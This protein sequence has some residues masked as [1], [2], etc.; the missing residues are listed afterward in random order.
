MSQIQKLGKPRY[1]ICHIQRWLSSQP[2]IM[3]QIEIVKML[4]NEWR[5]VRF[6][7]GSDTLLNTLLSGG[8][9]GKS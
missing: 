8:G 4:V 1:L 3:A 9:H 2:A 6:I 7:R 5:L